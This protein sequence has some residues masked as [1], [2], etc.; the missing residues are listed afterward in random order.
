MMVADAPGPRYF[1]SVSLAESIAS[2]RSLSGLDPAEVARLA[3]IEPARLAA[4]EG[5]A[6]LSAAELVALADALGVSPATL[7]GTCL[8]YT[9][10]S[11]RDRTRSRM[12]S[13]A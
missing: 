6:N 8:L 13:S 10:P 12:P 3:R 5:G 11:P 9:S 1:E 2:A 4:I 7:L